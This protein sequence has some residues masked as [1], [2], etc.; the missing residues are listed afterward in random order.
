MKV[1][2]VLLANYGVRKKE[3]E[4]RLT[5]NETCEKKKGETFVVLVES[6]LELHP[7]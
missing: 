3:N 5:E 7:W 1:I 6:A 4:P 2:D